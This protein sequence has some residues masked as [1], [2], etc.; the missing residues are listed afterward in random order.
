M[1][2]VAE[3][4]PK[5]AIFAWIYEVVEERTNENHQKKW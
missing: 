3:E 4:N 2:E 5:P 1:A